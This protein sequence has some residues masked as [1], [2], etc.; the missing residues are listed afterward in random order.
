LPVNRF[1]EAR[2]RHDAGMTL[3]LALAGA[4]FLPSFKI[5]L[6]RVAG[7]GE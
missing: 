6:G 5:T 3:H 1:L 2:L 7:D 4:S